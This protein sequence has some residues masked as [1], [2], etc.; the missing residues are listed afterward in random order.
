[1][2]PRCDRPHGPALG[3]AICPAPVGPRCARLCPAPVGPPRVHPLP[4]AVPRSRCARPH[5][6]RSACPALRPAT[7]AAPRAP[8]C[9]R[10]PAPRTP[11]GPRCARPHGP[12]L[13]PATYP[14]PRATR[15]ARPHGPTPC[16]A[17]ALAASRYNRTNVR[18]VGRRQ[19][20]RGDPG[21]SGRSA[22]GRPFQSTECPQSVHCRPIDRLADQKRNRARNLDMVVRLNGIPQDVVFWG[23]TVRRGRRTFRRSHGPPGGPADSRD[24]PR[25]DGP[26]R[27]ESRIQGGSR[28]RPSQLWCWRR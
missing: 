1:M 15:C 22:R 28:S 6:P 4:R 17:L 7:W 20:N 16:H 9:A 21:E 27:P 10:W 11:A 12:A 3:P 19:C 25:K 5:G 18:N 13:R 8:R 26:N 14:M 23:L 2:G 24:G